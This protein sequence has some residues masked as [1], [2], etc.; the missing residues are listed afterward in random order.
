MKSTSPSGDGPTRVVKLPADLGVDNVE[1]V[2]FTLLNDHPG[3]IEI[4]GVILLMAM[5]GA[6]VLARKQVQ[7]DERGQGAAATARSSSIPP[8]GVN[9]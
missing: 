9:A 4:A 6:V 5:L 3:S 1:G 8:T 7:I 2:A